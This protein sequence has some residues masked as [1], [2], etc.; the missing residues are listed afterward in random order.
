MGYESM[1]T[2]HSNIILKNRLT[3][4]DSVAVARGYI[5]DVQT[6]DTP[7]QPNEDQED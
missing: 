7:N 1:N 5:S 6:I 4:L 3:L 2:H